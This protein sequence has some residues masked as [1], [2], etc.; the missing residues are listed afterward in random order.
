MSTYSFVNA[1]TI[2]RDVARHPQGAAVADVLLH[3]FGLDDDA[4]ADLD[5]VPTPPGTTRLRDRARRH[6]AEERVAVPAPTPATSPV[7]VLDV[8]TIGAVDDVCEWVRTEVLDDAWLRAGALSVCRW[9]T[10][11]THVC[12]GV[13]AAWVGPSV[14]G[15]LGRAWQDWAAGRRQPAIDDAGL[16][17]VV[18]SIGAA[19][20]MA[21][22]DIAEAMA[23]WRMSGRSWPALMHDACWAIEITGRGR[24]AALAHLTAVRALMGVSTRPRPGVVAAVSMAVQAKVV[25]DVLP[26]RTVA[27]MCQPLFAHLPPAPTA[28]VQG[29]GRDDG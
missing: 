7:D 26:D 14:A 17:A 29:H 9:P 16:T 8:T 21:L 18:A 19:D 15:D 13:L 12:H 25:S 27:A 11:L 3:A 20:A 6:R 4:L 28:N 23:Q 1:A 2:A 24:T 22:D 5:C 10:A